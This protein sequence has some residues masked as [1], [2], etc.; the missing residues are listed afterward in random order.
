MKKRNKYLA[1]FS[2]CLFLLTACTPSVPADTTG[3]D[4]SAVDGPRPEDLFRVIDKEEYADRTKSAFLAQLVGFLSGHEFAK[5]SG[6]SRCRVAMPDSAFRICKGAYAGNNAMVKHTNKLLK[7]AETGLWEVWNDDDFSVDIVNLYI[8]RNMYKNHGSLAPYYITKGWVDY[9]V[10]DMG[11]GQRQVG[12][13]AMYSQNDQLPQ[14]GGNGEYGN[15]YSFVTEP[16]LGADTLGLTA[17]GMPYEAAEMGRIFGEATGDRD[18]VLWSQMFTVMFSLAYFE[19]DIPALI[20]TAAGVFPKGSDQEAVVEEV[21]ALYGQY[22]DNWRI[23]YKTFENRHYFGERTRQTNNTINCGFVLLDLLYGGGDYLETCKI[24]SLAGYDCEST[25]GIALTVVGIINGTKDLPEEVNTYVWQ[26][27]QGVIVNLPISDSG[28]VGTYMYAAK[29]PAR[30]KIAEILDLYQQNFEAVLAANGGYEE[31][32]KYYIPKTEF[33]PV[34]SVKIENAGFESGDL[35][36]YRTEGSVKISE[37]STSGRYAVQMKG[38][39]VISQQITGLKVGATYRLT[40]YLYATNPSTARLFA[41]CGDGEKSATVYSTISQA[42][43]YDE[44]RTVRRSLFFTATAETAT[45]GVRYEAESD[46]T[47]AILDDLSL[48][49]TD[50]RSAGTVSVSDLTSPVGSRVRVTVTAEEAGLAWLK[51]KFDNHGS[52]GKAELTINRKSSGV[53]CFYRT[54]PAS[55]AEADFHEDYVYLPV[56]LKKG[57]NT[58]SLVFSASKIYLDPEPEILFVSDARLPG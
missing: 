12:A 3:A 32:G 16:Y 57:E 44:Q 7:N 26:D 13:Y 43:N 30:L 33:L 49:R 34:D 50:E 23:A 21:F 29:L 56:P 45:V 6:S 17:A 39:S 55:V 40:A 37:F 58:V 38:N 9:D 47:E 46:A 19:S 14:F 48:V 1:F 52:I 18:N 31:D 10:Y 11:G 42:K 53:A 36:A 24:G 2:A 54:S 35:S 20:R 8:L 5:I 41:D 25:C 27:G 22:P 4:S 28:D 15:R 51:W